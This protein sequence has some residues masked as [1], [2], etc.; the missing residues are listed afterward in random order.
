MK[1]LGIVVAI[2]AVI[3]AG[4]LALIVFS[5]STGCGDV[6]I[7]I[8]TNKLPSSVGEFTGDQI[9]NAATIVN[10]G[11]SLG[12]T[13]EA[14][15][16]ALMVAITESDLRNL[17]AAGSDSG[18]LG[19]FQQTD[20]SRWG[21]STDRLTPTNASSNFYKALTDIADWESLTPTLAANAVQGSAD[22]YQYDAAAADAAAILAAFG[23]ENSNCQ[24]GPAGEV[25]AQ[26]WASPIDGVVGSPYGPRDA[27]CTNGYCTGGFHN[28]QDFEAP[29]GTPIYAVRGGTVSAAGPN[30][31]FGNW[32]VIDHGSGISSV[33]AH[34]YGDGVFVRTG[35]RVSAGQNIGAVGCSGVCTGP[36][37]H[38]EIRVNGERI[39]P[40]PFLKQVGLGWD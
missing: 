19:L 20:A 9:A 4:L 24:A 17:D 25:N 31:S 16:V 34:M 39:N 40:M 22:P 37:L 29:A 3:V 23:A 12:V 11:A 14:Q 36:H 21:T 10:V 7:S 6:G 26:G 8:N 35:D 13:V 1:L 15:T 28:G 32:I 18:R 30:A 38:F 2:P 5:S 33:Y 27:L